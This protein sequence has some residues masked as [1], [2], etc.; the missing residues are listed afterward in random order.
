VAPANR[1]CNFEPGQRP[2]HLLVANEPSPFARVFVHLLKNAFLKGQLMSLDVRAQL[3]KRKFFI[4]VRV[5][6]VK[7]T[8]N[9]VKWN[10]QWLVSLR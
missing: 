2:L 1:S 7:Q 4:K 10:L 5:H 6:G 3:G 8:V 9:A